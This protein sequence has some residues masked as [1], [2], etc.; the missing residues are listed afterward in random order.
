[1][2]G[3]G[4]MSDVQVK[5]YIDP[6]IMKEIFSSMDVGIA[7]Y[8]TEDGENFTVDFFN[9]A[10]RNITKLKEEDYIDRN[11]L[12]IFSSLEYS[13]FLKALKWVYN[14]GKSYRLPNFY[15]KDERI[16]LWKTNYIFR[17]SCLKVVSIFYDVT[18]NIELHKQIDQY[19][20]KNL[21]ENAQELVYT[22]DI[23]GRILSINRACEKIL[24]YKPKELLDKNIRDIVNAE[25]YNLL[26]ISDELKL[27]DKNFISNL[28]ARFIDSE[29]KE[30]ILELSR[31]ILYKNHSPYEIQVIAR[32]ITERKE[33]EEKIKYL[34]YHDKLTGLYNRTFYEEKLSLFNKKKVYPISVIMG[35][36]NSLKLVN[37]AFGHNE[38]DK[39][40]IEVGSILENSAL[41]TSI[42]ARIA[43]DEFIIITPLI[44]EGE[45][46]NIINSIKVN[47]ENSSLNPIKPSIALGYALKEKEEEDIDEVLKEAEGRMYRNK[48]TESKSLRSAIIFSLQKTLYESTPETS[49]HCER[50][51][52][53]CVEFGRFIGLSSADIDKLILLSL[54]HDI[55]KITIP[56]T[57]LQK[58]GPLTEEEWEA[59]KRHCQIG[60]NI[61]N[62]SPELAVIAEYILYHHERWDGGGYPRGLK[63]KDI[64]LLSRI[65][66]IVDAYDVMLHESYYKSPVTQKQALK[67]LYRCAGSQFDPHLVNK[68]ISMMTNNYNEK[69]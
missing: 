9:E 37:D 29:G 36:V 54:L 50:I 60:Y 3:Y 17:L 56:K 26:D 12:D 48:L 43:G 69:M 49:E 31:C 61:A 13:N 66:C 20:Y 51:K 44:T 1:M 15:Y 27:N 68:F 33:E 52:N 5:N 58:S 14:T 30:K 19:R 65:I 16:A 38:G 8:S 23:Q 25:D 10:A 39:L 28:E 67:E 22:R 41:S 35:D 55:G 40:L 21:F 11:I 2:E 7:I 64:P 57:V 18:D 46:V 32:D 45:T 42:V 4:V 24:K 6:N 62:S 53:I 59:V 63:G 34:S 47:C